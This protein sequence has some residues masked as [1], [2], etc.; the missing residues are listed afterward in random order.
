MGRAT[1]KRPLRIICSVAFSMES[2]RRPLMSDVGEVAEELGDATLWA[3]LV[4]PERE[5]RERSSEGERCPSTSSAVYALKSP[6]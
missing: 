3:G 1:G 4:S 2:R 5:G 6:A